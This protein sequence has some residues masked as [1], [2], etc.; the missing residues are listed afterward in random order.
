[1][2]KLT[3]QTISIFRRRCPPGSFRSLPRLSLR[4]HQLGRHPRQASHHP[5]QGP[6]ACPTTPRRTIIE[7]SSDC[8]DSLGPCFYLLIFRFFA[9]FIFS[10]RYTV[11]TC[12]S[13]LLSFWHCRINRG[14]AILKQ[15]THENC[16]DISRLPEAQ[17]DG[18]VKTVVTR[19]SSCR[20]RQGD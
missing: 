13:P 14:I 1:M 7:S 17:P 19:N 15:L 18:A 6:S 20:G 8:I 3:I 11:V 5:A 4:R 2:L 16:T 10:G 9:C 12:M